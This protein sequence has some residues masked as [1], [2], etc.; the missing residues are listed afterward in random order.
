MFADSK[1]FLA[2]I[3]TQHGKKNDGKSDGGNEREVSNKWGWM[4]ESSSFVVWCLV[5]HSNLL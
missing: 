3:I 5:K 4:T 1:E 2:F